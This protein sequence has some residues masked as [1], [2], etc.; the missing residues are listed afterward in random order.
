MAVS[1]Q[2]FDQWIERGRNM[3]PKV[4]YMISVCDTFNYEDYPVYC[5]S[6]KAMKIK[7]REVE[8]AK[9]SKVNEV[10]ELSSGKRVSAVTGKVI[11][12]VE[13]KER[14][15]SDIFCKVFNVDDKQ[16][17]VQKEYTDNEDTPYGLSITIML[18]GLKAKLTA[19]F[20]EQEDMDKA[21][22][23]YNEESAKEVLK[24]MKEANL[25]EDDNDTDQ[26][27]S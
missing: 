11:E 7:V 12:D 5:A 21:F 10:I 1:K 4:K 8:K 26:E 14:D 24:T 15:T 22:D 9:M 19:E 3:K 16:V 23:T 18:G 2:E 13:N 27:G 20:I 6:I 17:L 25:T